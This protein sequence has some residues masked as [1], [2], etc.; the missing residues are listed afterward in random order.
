LQIIRRVTKIKRFVSM[1]VIGEHH[2]PPFVP[3]A[4]SATCKRKEAQTEGDWYV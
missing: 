1:V 2:N 3:I 4:D